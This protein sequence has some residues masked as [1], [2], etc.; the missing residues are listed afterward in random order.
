MNANGRI[1]NDQL[2]MRGSAMS[3][4]PIIIGT[5][6]LAR[7]TNAGM[8]APKIMTSA[9]IVVISLKNSGCTNCRPGLNS[10]AR[11]TIA[12]AA[13]DEEHRQREDE[14]QRADVLVVGR[15]QP[16]M[17]EAVRLVIVVVVRVMRVTGGGWR[18]WLRP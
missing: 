16:A 12:I 8:T 3:G 17:E 7:P 4:A 6:Q 1:Q 5:I 9:C 18:D 15:E 14:V 2:F 10:S 11:I 13:A